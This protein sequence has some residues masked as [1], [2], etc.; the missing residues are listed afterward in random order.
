MSM[1]VFTAIPLLASMLLSAD[2]AAGQQALE[3]SVDKEH[4]S[5]PYRE[6]VDAFFKGELKK[7]VGGQKAADGQFPWQVSLGVAWVASPADGHF[8]GGSIL[9]ESWI[10]TAAHC[11]DGNTAADIIVTAGTAELEQGGQRR[12]V[13]KILVKDGYEDAAKGQDVALIKLRSPLTL[14]GNTSA[15]P[16]VAKGTDVSPETRAITS[17]FGYTSE[18]G[19]V[20]AELNFVD[21]PIVSTSICNAPQSYDGQITDQM[22]C[23]GNAEGGKDSCQGD[24][25]GPLVFSPPAKP[26]LIGIVSW[27]EGC[28]RPLKY[29][30]Y[31]NVSAIAEWVNS[32][33]ADAPD[34]KFKG[35]Q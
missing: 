32:C 30:I 23:A 7:I 28:A 6:R 27:G 11:V 33:A 13:E 5:A 26:E 24:S 18:G 3:A 22:I 16:L 19:K 15:I 17:G 2:L 8:C 4:G 34:C 9:N 10:V 21:I 1:R 31:T 20:S 14:T 35:L 25:G 12:N 29:G